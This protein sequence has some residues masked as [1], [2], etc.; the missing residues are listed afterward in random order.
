[1][2][3]SGVRVAAST[4]CFGVIAMA[5]VIA[6]PSPVYHLSPAADD[7]EAVDTSASARVPRAFGVG[8]GK[9]PFCLGAVLMLSAVLSFSAFAL[10]DLYAISSK[11][12]LP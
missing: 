11:P 7:A 9:T 3:F 2:L 5:V 1:M 6:Q 8:P 4:L 10:F 12:V